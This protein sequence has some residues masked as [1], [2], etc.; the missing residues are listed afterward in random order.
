VVRQGL[1]LTATGLT[2]GAVGSLLLSRFLQ[3]LLFGVGST[4]PV[5]FAGVVVVLTAVALA[6]CW[7]PAWRAT[8]VSPLEAIR[9]E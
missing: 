5:T 3:R 7:A 4:D 1:T 2:I 6:A 8:R 9:G